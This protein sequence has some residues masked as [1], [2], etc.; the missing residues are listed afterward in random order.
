MRRPRV[1]E[2]AIVVLLASSACTSVTGIPTAATRPSSHAMDQGATTPTITSPPATTSSTLVTAPTA[3]TPVTPKSAAQV[4]VAESMT[5]TPLSSA[6]TA[7]A[8]TTFAVNGEQARGVATV[9]K[10]VDA[11]N[12]GDVQGALALFAD[13]AKVWFSACRYRTGETID[14]TGKTAIKSWLSE[15]AAEHSRLVLGSIENGNPEQPVGIVGMQL[16]RETSDTIRKLGY[17][18]GIIPA[19]GTVIRFD[20]GGKILSIGS[21]S[22]GGPASICQLPQR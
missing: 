16:T 2:L 10:F 17:P 11:Y 19:G 18:A 9:I 7:I 4:P 1:T 6:P 8:P 14:G 20:R 5:P 21:G 22:F 12:S 3:T 13:S 15:A